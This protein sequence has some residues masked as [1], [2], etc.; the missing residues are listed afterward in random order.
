MKA[1]F[2]VAIGLGV[3]EKPLSTRLTA[4]PADKILLAGAKAAD[5]TDCPVRLPFLRVQP[6]F[7]GERR[8]HVVAFFAV[9]FRMTFLASE[10]QANVPEFG[11]EVVQAGHGKLLRAHS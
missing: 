5:T 1:D 10:K 2:V 6:S 3:V 7:V 4:Q 11:G 9:S 8:Q